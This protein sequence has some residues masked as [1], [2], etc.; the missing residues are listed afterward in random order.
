MLPALPRARPLAAHAR[1]HRQ[2]DLAHHFQE[3]EG[4]SGRSEHA[5]IKVGLSLFLASPGQPAETE[6]RR[7]VGVDVETRHGHA[8]LVSSRQVVALTLSQIAALGGAASVAWDKHVASDKGRLK[9]ARERERKEKEKERQTCAD[10]RWAEMQTARGDGQIMAVVRCDLLL[11]D[12]SGQ[13][14]A[15]GS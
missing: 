13:C 4:Q 15:N 9:R 8:Q 10:E 12:G 2:L 11:G 14:V 1:W 5:Q 6:T 7:D 3:W